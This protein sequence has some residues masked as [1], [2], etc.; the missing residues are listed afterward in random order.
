MFSKNILCSTNFA[1]I[2]ALYLYSLMKTDFNSNVET[3]ISNL[4][5]IYL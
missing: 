2:F 5:K 4:L 1:Y 3:K